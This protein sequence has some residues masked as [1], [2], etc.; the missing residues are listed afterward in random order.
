MLRYTVKQAIIE[1]LKN[2]IQEQ[3]L[4]QSLMYRVY[5]TPTIG[6]EFDFALQVILG[7]IAHELAHGSSSSPADGSFKSQFLLSVDRFVSRDLASACVTCFVFIL[8]DR[9]FCPSPNKLEQYL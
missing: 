5:T 4:L 8:V 9:K 1:S 2:Y 7:L 3:K 6:G